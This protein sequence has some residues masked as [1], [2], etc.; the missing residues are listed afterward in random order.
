MC[1]ATLAILVKFAYREGVEVGQLIA[2]RFLVAASGLWVLSALTRQA[3]WRLPRRSLLVLA[4]MGLTLYSLQA[5]SFI[6]AVR[7]LPASLVSLV[8]YTYP[9]L[10]AIGARLVFGRPLT[11][12]HAGALVASFLGVAL[13]VGGIGSLAL[14]PGLFFAALAPVVYTVYI[15]AGDFA[16][17]DGTRPVAAA[18]VV[19]TGSAITFTLAAAGLGQLRPPP[20]PLAAVLL[21]AIGL[22]PTV[23][24]IT[25]FLAALPRIGAG[26]TALL[27]TA[28]PVV[29]V[30][31]AALLLGDRLGPAQLAGGALVVGAVVALQWP[32]P[33]GGG[34]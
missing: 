19:M 34:P 12:A 7:T 28:E 22:V 6:Y 23:A 26:R 31:L 30:G 9:A 5:F 1:F 27:S 32:R 18:T 14:T 33:D 11:A 17:R 4:G 13:L 8:L 16:M 10:V 15:L 29:T 2:I 3:P 24:A 20:T 21:L 25:L